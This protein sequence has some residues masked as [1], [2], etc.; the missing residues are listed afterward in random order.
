MNVVYSHILGQHAAY[1]GALD[2][3]LLAF[4]RRTASWEGNPRWVVNNMGRGARYHQWYAFDEED[5]EGILRLIAEE[6]AS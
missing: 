4:A 1:L 6:L 5:A 3:P 2:G